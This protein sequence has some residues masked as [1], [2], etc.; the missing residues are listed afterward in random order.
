MDDYIK[1]IKKNSMIDE[2]LYSKLDVKRGLR[3]KDGSGVLAGLT[4]ISKVVGFEKIDNEI[5]PVEGKLEYRGKSIEELTNHILKEGKYGFERV[6]FLLLFGEEPSE[7]ELNNFSRR[8]NEQSSLP[9]DFIE[10]VILRQRGKNVMNV[11]ARLV[12]SLYELDGSADSISVEDLVKQSINIISKFPMLVVYSCCSTQNESFVI[13]NPKSEFSTAENFLHMLRK[14]GKFTEAEAKMLDLCLV[15]H[16]DHGGGNNSTFTTRVISSSAT[17]SYSA[18]SGAIGSL[19]GPLHGGANIKA[20]GMM[21]EIKN[22]CNSKEDISNYLKK[23]MK[24]EA[25]DRSGKIYGFGHV[26]YTKSDPRA[27]ILRKKA[28]EFAEEKGRGKEYELYR[29]VEELAPNV[30][31]EVKGGNKVIS[32][33]VDFYSGFIYSCL[34][35]PKELYTP[36]FAM[37]RVVGWCAHRIEELTTSRRIIRPAYGFV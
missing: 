19:K 29:F 21:E 13:N 4:N 36:L 3:N 34:G 2:E 14:N 16:M 12:L 15:L 35:I 31:K 24:K 18:I 8:L 26:V 11:L 28:K 5:V 23:I 7:E 37:A 25:F 20:E 10:N 1:L 30:F 9:K 22:N 27:K 17:D 33:N 6:A 32:A